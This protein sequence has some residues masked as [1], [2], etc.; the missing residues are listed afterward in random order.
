MI[1]LGVVGVLYMVRATPTISHEEQLSANSVKSARHNRNYYECLTP[2][3]KLYHNLSTWWN[4]S[5]VNASKTNAS[6]V[7]ATYKQGL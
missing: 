3:Q 2:Q 4:A 5:V 7:N 1:L 6:K